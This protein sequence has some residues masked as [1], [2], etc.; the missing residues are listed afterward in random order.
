[1]SSLFPENETPPH[2]LGFEYQI[3]RSWRKSAA[4][5]VRAGI[6]EVRIP[7]GINEKW[8]AEFVYEKRH[9][10][11]K[12]LAAM[13]VKSEQAPSLKWQSDLLW[14]GE[15]KKLLYV[16]GKKKAVKI[17]DD[18]L[19]IQG[20][21]APDHAQRSALLQRFF[22]QQA[23]VYL[24][25][26]T[27]E[28]SEKIGL[29]NTLKQVTFRRTKTKWGHCTNQGTIQYNWL[30]MGAPLHVIDYLIYHELTHLIHPNHS[31]RYWGQVKTFYPEFELGKTWL[32]KNGHRLSWC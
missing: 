19:Q 25:T 26:R 30:I 18:Q 8:V 2:E 32:K 12:K 27:L 24:T 3:K 6:V 13:A 28:I 1:M 9:W 11:L 20:P 31:A 7:F 17:V 21:N 10:V 5:H 23:K 4:I 29:Q 16:W 14:M 22:K 15:N